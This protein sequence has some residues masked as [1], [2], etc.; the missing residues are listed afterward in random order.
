[1][2]TKY[3]RFI[4]HTFLFIIILYKYN[5]VFRNYRFFNFKNSL[6]FFFLNSLFI[7]Y[8]QISFK[9]IFFLV[10]KLLNNIIKSINNIK[11]KNE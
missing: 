6:I 8:I 3:F 7:F 2:T 9:S 11:K 10:I 1:M 5:Q 4:H